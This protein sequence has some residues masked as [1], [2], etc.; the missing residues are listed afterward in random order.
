[1]FLLGALAVGLVSIAFAAAA[2]RCQELFAAAVGR[3]AWLPLVATPTLFLL[4]ALLAHACFPGSQG[5][6]IPQAMAARQLRSR[7]ERRG[8]LSPR[9]AAG[10]IALTLLGLLAGG[11][12]G[13]EGPTVQIGASMM[14]EAARIGRLREARGLIL[15]GSAAG[16]AAAFNT[17]LAG[18]VFAIEEMSRSFEQRTSGLVLYAVIVAGLVSLGLLGNYSYFGDAA[19]TAASPRDWVLVVACGACGGLAGGLFSRALLDGLR[20]VRRIAAQHVLART[21]VVALGCGLVVALIGMASGGAT[22]GT[23]YQPA[24]AAVEGAAPPAWFWLAKLAATLATALSGI[25]GGIFAPSLAV[26]AGLGSALGGLFSGSPS[27]AAIVGMAGYFSG[28]VQ[29]PITAFVIILEMTRGDAAVLPLMVA[30]VLGY[31]VSRLVS[32]HSL[33]HGLAADFVERARP[34]PAGGDA[35]AEAQLFSR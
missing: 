26:G 4:S 15:A 8:L 24:R 30:A 1:M 10:K 11:S 31:G 6:G 29:A 32:P 16:V 22:F 9:L 28:V 14:L 3:F 7:R 19:A 5:S 20:F 21:L 34:E 35:P 13:R 2:D 33:Y 25:P 12:V 17:P 23:G 18:I 27:L